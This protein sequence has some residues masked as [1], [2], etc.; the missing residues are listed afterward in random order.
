MKQEDRTR[1]EEHKQRL[2]L[3][4]AFSA[5]VF[6]LL[7]VTG[8]IIAA[9]VALLIRRGVLHLGDIDTMKELKDI[10][11]MRIVLICVA[12]G[13]ALTAVTAR[14]P[15]KPVN[16]V[17]NAMNRLASGDYHTRLSFSGILSKHP[18]VREAEHS[19]NAMAKELENTELLRSDFI[20][21][22]S[23]EFKTPI[24]SIAGFA[25]L[26]RRGGLTEQEREEYLEII[27]NESLRLSAMATNVLNMTRV[28]NQTILTDV[29]QFNLSEQLRSC[30]LQ[31]ENRWTKK[32]L[33]WEMAQDEYN[34]TGDEELL[35]EVWLNLLDNA[36]KF[37]PE[38][39]V[40]RVAIQER[41][42]TTAV[43]I[44][45]TGSKI[46]AED[47]ERIFQ[48]FYQA[49]RSHATEGHGIGLA[50]V[51]RVVELHRGT[52][53]VSSEENATTFTVV[54]PGG[55]GCEEM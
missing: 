35:R 42:F 2:S 50:V 28:E 33:E 49:D 36:I 41:E 52:V 3:T 14:H 20:N 37:S 44:T 53:S 27:E 13:T 26:L 48:K 17:I 4:L 43:S 54:L 46:P 18:T 10:H 34:V 38:W 5:V 25:K 47:K 40:I 51:K 9:A 29:K 24:V 32:N 19:F 22:F 30:V 23:H 12:V 21:N 7:L 8:V 11:L 39:S 6:C 16:Q 55:R 45:N 31:L 1:L 15:L